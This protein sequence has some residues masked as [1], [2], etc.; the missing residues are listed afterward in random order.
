MTHPLGPTLT[1]DRLTLRPPQMGDFETVAAYFASERSAKLGGPVPRN[2]VWTNFLSGAGQWALRGYG[3]WYVEHQGRLIGRAG[4]Y[5]P[6]FWPEPELSYTLFHADVE[7][8]GFATEAARA[9][10]QG[11]RDLGVPS[12][13][14]S[15]MDNN[16]QSRAVCDRLGATDE[17]LYETPYGEMRKFRHYGTHPTKGGAQ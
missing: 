8:Q 16:P 7:D 15:V 5:H 3:F 12:L 2:D 6:V 9:A 14:S 17:G 13:I 4:V 1:T 11:A 10:I